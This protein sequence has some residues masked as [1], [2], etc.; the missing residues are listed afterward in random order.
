MPSLPWAHTLV[1]GHHHSFSLVF[2]PKSIYPAY[3]RSVPCP[4]PRRGLGLQVM[5][6]DQASSLLQGLLELQHVAALPAQCAKRGDPVKHA[7]AVTPGPQ[8]AFTLTWSRIL[9][10]HNHP[11]P[12]MPERLGIPTALRLS[13]LCCSAAAWAV[14]R[15]YI[16]NMRTTGR[17]LSTLC[18]HPTTHSEFLC[19]VSAYPTH[20]TY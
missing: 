5:L 19:F 8:M 3:H 13:L 17:L 10:D 14:C 16:R 9:S 12:L 2:S 20:N 1:C 6:W 15:G 7:R 11:S 18:F 4:A